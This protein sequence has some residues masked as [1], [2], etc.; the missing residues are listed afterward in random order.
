MKP[1]SKIN[2]H[3]KGILAIKCVRP[4]LH[5]N[6]KLPMAHTPSYMRPQNNQNCIV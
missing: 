1:F 5:T 4:E 6:V 2:V 3:I